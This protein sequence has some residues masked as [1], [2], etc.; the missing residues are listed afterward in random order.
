MLDL[1]PTSDP[2]MPTF[3]DR[4]SGD[5]NAP[6]F[7]INEQFDKILDFYERVD[8]IEDLDSNMDVVCSYITHSILRDQLLPYA[9][10]LSSGVIFGN[11]FYQSAVLLEGEEN[12]KARA[13][14]VPE[15]SEICE[16]ETLKVVEVPEHIRACINLANDMKLNGDELKYAD[17]LRGFFT[18]KLLQYPDPMQY[19]EK[20]A[21]LIL[22]WIKFRHNFAQFLYYL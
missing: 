12:A 18:A 8:S 11:L 20:L 21:S 9:F 16:D 7:D 6:D 17:Y 14:F 5:S 19:L 22:D 13:N 15:I 10:S 1:I 3:I 2:R 4:M